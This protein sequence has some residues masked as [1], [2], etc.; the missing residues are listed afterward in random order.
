LDIAVLKFINL[1]I[2]NPA[3]DLFFKFM[4]DFE[5]WRW[6]IALAIV[7]LAWKGGVRGRW[8]IAACVVT[9]AVVDPT[10]HYFLKPLFARLR[11]CK[12]PNL[13]WV[14][15]I[16]GCGGRYGF[17]SS[18]AGNLM[19][20]AV[21]SGW[22]YRKSWYFVYPLAIIVAI[23]RVYLGVHYPS[24]VL[25]GAAYGAGVGILIIVIAKKLASGRTEKY[26]LAEHKEN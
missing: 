17:P 3:F 10:I 16:D 21:V 20:L 25:G 7:I 24:D 13:P 2:A 6:P 9:I 11:P 5:F 18:H 14:R 23:S 22:F 4:G 26:L 8:F 15:A 12:D 1:T 19:S